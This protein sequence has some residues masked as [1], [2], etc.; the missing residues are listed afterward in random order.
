MGNFVKLPFYDEINQNL[1]HESNLIQVIL[2]PRQVGKTTSVLHYLENTY[3]GKSLFKSADAQFSATFDWI[4]QIWQEA[5]IDY[6]LLVIDE[7]QKLENW[8]EVIKKLWD[9]NQRNKKPLKLLLLGSSSLDIQK[10]LTESLT[11]RFQL[12]NAYHWNYLESSTLRKMTFEDYLKFGGYP[13]SYSFM[14][15]SDQFVD[16]LKI[17]IVKTVIEKDILNNHTVKSPALFKQAFEII[18]A[19]PGQEICYTKL[20]GQLQYKGNVDIVKYYI[21]LYEGA[22][23]IKSIFKYYGKEIKIR[24]SSPK[25]RPMCPTFYYL[26]IQDDYES[27]ER[28][29]IFEAV[30]GMALARLN[31]ELF[32]WREGKFE[33]DYVLKKGKKIIAIE[34]KSGRRKNSRG[35]EEFVKKFPEARTIFITPENYNRIGSG[36]LF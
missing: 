21:S 27:D 29:R 16:Y 24:T 13:K 30:V 5:T 18:M 33:V 10:G 2:G 9:K 15:N 19:Y 4:S 6:D 17:S 22:F 25:L 8:A 14:E 36:E 11:G 34:V 20:L 32:Y 12:I 31:Y 23:L 28:G 7:I 26:S 3:S 35:L 1:K